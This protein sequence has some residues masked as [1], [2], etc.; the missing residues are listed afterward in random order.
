VDHAGEDDLNTMEEGHFVWLSAMEEKGMAPMELLRSAT[1]NIALAY[2]MDRD[3]GTLE[4]GKFADFV[5]LDA[6]PLELPPLS[7]HPQGNKSWDSY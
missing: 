4:P 5:I 7:A 3:L 2:G 6:N 1:R